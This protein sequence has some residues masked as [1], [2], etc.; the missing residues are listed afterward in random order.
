MLE[1]LP[2]AELLR[3]LCQLVTKDRSVEAEILAHLGEVD[4]R[5]LY[6]AEGC[7]SMFRFCTDV[8]H[9]SEATAFHRIRADRVCRTYT[10]V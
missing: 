6:L 5:Q 10:I 9:F 2:N 4:A 7:P 3:A 1:S 8:L